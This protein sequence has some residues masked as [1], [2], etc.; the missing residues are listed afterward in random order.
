MDLVEAVEALAEVVWAMSGPCL[1]LKGLT[2]EAD[3]C[4][5]TWLAESG[6]LEPEFQTDKLC[7]L[8]RLR[9]EAAPTGGVA[10]AAAGAEGARAAAAA[11][12]AKAAK[13]RRAGAGRAGK[14]AAKVGAEGGGAAVGAGGPRPV[15]QVA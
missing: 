7:R 8:S 11:A 13:A 10:A 4:R 2:G 1:G 6:S 12:A 14:P 5:Q 3:G 9:L 15:P